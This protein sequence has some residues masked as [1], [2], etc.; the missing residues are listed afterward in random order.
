[1]RQLS[2]QEIDL[3]ASISAFSFIVGAAALLCIVGAASVVAYKTQLPGRR[4]ILCSLLLVPAWWGFEQYMGGS[5]EM[6]F[7]P[8]AL[9]AT[10]IV[11]SIIAV[12]FSTGYLRMCF[13]FLKQRTASTRTG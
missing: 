7:G 13:G 10:A 11:Y 1:M 5:L 12:I 8:E 4:S 2:A 9:L 3:L 6:T